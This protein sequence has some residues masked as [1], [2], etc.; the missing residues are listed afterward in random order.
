MYQ[1][2]EIN[3]NNQAKLVHNFFGNN[4]TINTPVIIQPK[5]T[6]N[7]PNDEYEKEADAMADKVM[8]MEQPFVQAK[9]LSITSVQRK[10]A[11]CEEEEKKAQR[12]EMN[13][14]ETTTDHTLE[15]YVGNLN[16]SGQSLSNEMRSFY[17]PRF[18][19]DFSNVKV[20]TDS[21]AAKSAQSINALA[22]TS[23]NSVVFN[24]GQYSPNTDT[25]KRLLGHELT[26]VVQ[27]N[28]SIQ[29]KKIQRTI[30]DGHDLNALRF[31]GNAVLEAVYDDERLLK[32]G[33]KGAAVRI[34]QQA[35]LDSGMTLPI[36]GVDGDFGPETENA[37][38]TFQRATGL[39]GLDRDGIVGPTTIGWLDQRFSTSPTPAG[40]SRAA[41]T[42]CARF[43]TID[44]DMVSLRGS[45]GNPTLDLNYANSVF[46]Q[47]CVRFNMAS[48]LSASDADSN[49]W[50]GG[51]NE[52]DNTSPCGALTA[53][54]NNLA[55]T[56]TAQLNLNSRF[57]V[58]YVDSLRD[59]ARAYSVPPFCATSSA[60]AAINM[61]AVSNS[62][63]PRSLAHEF[64]HILLNSRGH[65]PGVLDNLMQPT[66]T[67][68]AE[69]LT[70]PDCVTIF[71]N[72]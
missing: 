35:L 48:G 52:L 24:S 47:C 19:Y 14:N 60:A 13:G 7:D 61:A 28:A 45:T 17:E 39:S 43:K 4:K 16:G 36:H 3:N 26:H 53:E 10:C 15:S 38:R 40:T 25:G 58:F 44:V 22:Y 70:A 66:N 62:G 51:N 27:Q 5:L 42:G 12:K 65:A 11:H 34:L 29:T 68:T 33:S 1:H 63:Q 54:E 18:G 31:Q 2:A 49:T 57:R 67:A 59:G 56:A 8:R 71:T 21:I 41:T 46:N 50:L 55:T 32:K 64:G 6:I 69:D 20:H 37:V 72:A 30:G 9:Q 23:G